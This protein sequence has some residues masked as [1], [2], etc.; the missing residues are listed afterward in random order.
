MNFPSPAARAVACAALLLA[1][2]PARGAG[3]PRPVTV[4][5]CGEAWRYERVP[6]RAVTHDVNITELFLYL[7]LGDRLVGYSGIAATKEIDPALRGQLDTVPSLGR[8][9]MSL[10]AIMGVE[11][12]FVFGGWN[13]GF[14][15]GQ[16]TPATL[17]EFGIA[18]YILTESCVRRIKRENVSL[19]DT[20]A[21]MLAIGRIFAIEAHARQKVAEQRA[22]LQAVTAR[23]QG[24]APRPRVFVYDSGTDAPTT[25]GRFGMPHAMI[26]AAGGDNIFADIPSNWPRGNWEAVVERD[27]QWIVIIDYDRPGPQGKIDFLLSRPELGEVEAIRKRSFVV[28][29]YAEATPGPRNVAAVRKLARAF[30]PG[31]V[32]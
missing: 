17:A 29:S 22:Q 19:E 15:E 16:V 6:Q 20:F 13:Y 9:G 25:S 26:E 12:D 11:A 10:E 2:A 8:Q 32:Q 4:E 31:R 18:S 24:V 3:A 27:P 23:L 28:L 1:C 5:V 14:R 21:D 30:H 7:G